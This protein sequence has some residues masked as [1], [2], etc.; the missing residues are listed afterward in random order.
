MP[1]EINPV[2]KAGWSDE[3]Q[4]REMIWDGYVEQDFFV[5]SRAKIAEMMRKAF[6]NDGAI[7]GAIGSVG[8]VQ[9]IIYLSIGQF[10]YSD[11]WALFETFNYVS[12]QYRRSTNAKDMISFAKRCSDDLGIKLPIGVVSNERTKAKMALYARQLGDPV[13]GYF[14]YNPRPRITALQA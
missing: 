6:D 9:A 2:R 14:V 4:L 13:G 1:I 11:E 3:P 12:P 5:P 10:E 7:L 8:K